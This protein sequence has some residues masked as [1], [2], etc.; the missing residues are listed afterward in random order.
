MVSIATR[1]IKLLI[2]DDS[3]F[4]RQLIT[5]MMASYTNVK[6]DTASNGKIAL[7]KIKEHKPDVMTLDIE[8]DVMNGLELLQTMRDENIF[9]PTVMMS[10]LTKKNG[11]GEMTIK[12]LELGATDFISKPESNF[13]EFEFDQLAQEIYEKISIAINVP[14]NIIT[15]SKPIKSLALKSNLIIPKILVIGSSAGGPSALYQIFSTLPKINIP[16]III[17]HIPA[18]F[19]DSLAKRLNDISD[20]DVKVAEDG[21]TIKP[22]VAYVAAGDYHLIVKQN[23]TISL[24]QEPSYKG[25]RPSIDITLSSIAKV[26]GGRVL[27]VILTGIGNDGSEGVEEISQLGGKCIVQNKET[28]MIFGMPESIIEDNNADSIVALNKIPEEILHYLANWN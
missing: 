4:I 21:E 6:I 1:E 10:K 5:D 17:Q 26:Y 20:I 24:N 19:T 14:R 9:V 13:M 15:I 11:D 3:A 22:N 28:S 23:G 12:S 16:I 2:V 7:Q 8:M 18:G 25:V 27:S